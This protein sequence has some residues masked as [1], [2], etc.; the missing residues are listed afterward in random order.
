M[1]VKV[2]DTVLVHYVGTFDNGEVFDSSEGGDPLQFVVGDNQVIEGFEK[3]VEGMEVGESRKLHIPAAEAY[4]EPNEE[5]VIQVPIDQVPDD[6][7]LEEGTEIQVGTP[8]GYVIP[9]TI[10]TIDTEAGIVHIDTNH[11]LAGMA[12]NFQIELVEIL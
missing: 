3:G 7:P 11:P 9:A 8:E 10:K 6:I 1:A 2:G 4:G 12:L 5:A